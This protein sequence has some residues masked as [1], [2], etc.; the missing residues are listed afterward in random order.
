MDKEL[1]KALGELLDEKLGYVKKDISSL[2]DDVSSLKNDVSNVKNDV[3]NIKNDLSNMKSD[4]ELIKTQQKEHGVILRILE[5]KAN[6]NKAEHDKLS[7]DI[8]HLS[9]KVEDMR[10]DLATVEV[11]TARNMEN[12]ANLKIIK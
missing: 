11:V 12:I 1:L 8:I 5:D 2:K 4:I 6:T 10:K 9:A 7:N 3:S